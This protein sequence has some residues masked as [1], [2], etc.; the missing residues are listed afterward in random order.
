MFLLRLMLSP[1]TQRLTVDAVSLTAPPPSPMGAPVQSY[2]V[3]ALYNAPIAYAKSYESP[4]LTKSYAAP[5]AE[6]IA[7]NYG[8]NISKHILHSSIFNVF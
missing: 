2:G 5:I 7:V 3:P 8:P 1:S 6:P 4:V